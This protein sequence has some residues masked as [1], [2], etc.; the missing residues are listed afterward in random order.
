M[1]FLNHQWGIIL[2]PQPPHIQGKNMNKNMAAELSSLPCF[3]AFGV[4]ILSRSLFIF[5]PCMW[6][7]G[8]TSAFLN[9]A[10]S[11]GVSAAARKQSYFIHRTR[12]FLKVPEGHHPRGTTLREALR[13]NLPLR[14]LSGASVG[15]SSRVLR[16]LRGALR[17][18]PRVVALRL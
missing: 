9:Q 18:F 3:E 17:D 1:I 13:G 11:Q 6:E 15:V 14:G 2:R 10:T 7:A 16:G 5:L 8:V 4:H 12:H